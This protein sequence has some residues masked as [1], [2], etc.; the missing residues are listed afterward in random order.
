MPNIII[1]TC[2][3]ISNYDALGAVGRHMV[4]GG[5]SNKILLSSGKFAMV[6]EKKQADDA[7][8]CDCSFQVEKV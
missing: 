8:R 7:P 3:K 1:N 4:V 6:N 5:H 2:D